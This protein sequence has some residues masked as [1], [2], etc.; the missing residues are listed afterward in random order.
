MSNLFAKLQAKAQQTKTTDTDYSGKFTINT[1][2]YPAKIRLAYLD[3]S[4]KGAAFVALDLM[5]NI[6]GKSRQYKEDIYISNR[7]GELTYKDKKTGE[8]KPLPGFV[9]VDTLCKLAIGK[10][11]AEL[12]TETKK[13]KI[14]NRKTKQDENLDKEIL[15][16]LIGAEIILGI[17]E[18]EHDH[19]DASKVGE[20]QL[21]NCIDKVFSSDELTLPELE[22]KAEPKFLAMWKEQKTDK[23][24]MRALNKGKAAGTAGKPAMDGAP[25]T[26]KSLFNKF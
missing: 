9:T 26:A 3:T 18:E 11:F 10:P 22:A 24:I 6:N 16:D 19:W 20:T 21:K 5:L 4:P 15:M 8:D 1:G 13:I 7:D 12:E 14:K 2:A 25:K 17:A 23:V